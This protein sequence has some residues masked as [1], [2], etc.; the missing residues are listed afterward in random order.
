MKKVLSLILVAL[1][2]M[3]ANAEYVNG[4]NYSFNSSAKTAKIKS[5][6]Y[7]GNINIPST[8]YYN[9]TTYSVTE[10]GQYA[11]SQCSGMTSVTIPKSVKYIGSGAFWDCSGL[12]S[13]TILCSNVNTGKN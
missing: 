10:I 3:V 5:G 9:G 2:P 13:I 1:L 4:I 7:S 8:V 12:S 11:F 6:S